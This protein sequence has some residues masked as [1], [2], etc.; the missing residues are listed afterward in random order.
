MGVRKEKHNCGFCEEAKTYT[1]PDCEN[2]AVDKIYKLLE[3]IDL[4]NSF[5]HDHQYR[6]DNDEDV[7]N[8]AHCEHGDFFEERY[9]ALDWNTECYCVLKEESEYTDE[10]R[11][12]AGNTCEHWQRAKTRNN[13]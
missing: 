11:I 4:K 12:L 5:D 10:N 13:V 3:A 7:K 6:N 8:C 1:N 2:C 9:I